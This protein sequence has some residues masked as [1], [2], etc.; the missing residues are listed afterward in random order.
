MAA[1]VQFGTREKW[2]G[3]SCVGGG[4]NPL[5]VGFT[6]VLYRVRLLNKSRSLI[7]SQRGE[8]VHF[9]D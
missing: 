9:D 6:R 1:G 4:A 7:T 8:S 5:V 3:D 2:G